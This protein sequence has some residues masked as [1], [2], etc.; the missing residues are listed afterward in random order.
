VDQRTFERHTLTH[1]ARETR[2][3]IGCAVRQTGAIE[4]SRRCDCR[5]PKGVESRKEL[6]IFQGCQFGIQKQIVTEDADR[7][8]QRDAL[9]GGLMTT[10]EDSSAA[11][12]Q[13]RGQHRQERGL[14]CPVRPQQANDAS[15]SGAERD[16]GHRA[17]TTEMA[18]DVLDSQFVEINRWRAWRGHAA[19]SS[20]PPR[21]P[22]CASSSSP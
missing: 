1:A 17:T 8:T 22:G 21:G 6:Q 5:F 7:T 14:S 10:V 16:T 3:R 4:G 15:A 19:T 20:P 12:P 9:S 13:E 11:R 2:Y 18:R